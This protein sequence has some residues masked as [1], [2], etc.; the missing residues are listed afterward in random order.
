ME[1]LATENT[2]EGEEGHLMDALLAHVRH[3]R[4]SNRFDDDFSIIDARFRQVLTSR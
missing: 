2:R 4:G 3:R 1:Y